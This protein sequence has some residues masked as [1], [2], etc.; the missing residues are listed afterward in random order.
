MPAPRLAILAPLLLASAGLTATG[1]RA[2]I[3][4]DHTG[5]AI[6]DDGKAEIA[7]YEV[8]RAQ[9]QYGRTNPQTFPV[10]TYLVKHNY[11]QATES[12]AN[13]GGI[14]AF[15]WALFYEFESGAYQYKRS[16][17]INSARADLAPL[18]SSFNSFDWCSNLYRE[19]AFEADGD[20]RYLQRSDDYGNAEKSFRA[21]ENAY[22]WTTLPLVV[23][24]LDL[25][26]GAVRF[27][28]LLEDGS[29]V[30]VRAELA[31]HE[32]VETAAGTLEA[33]KIVLRYD[34]RA[35]SLIGEQASSEEHYFRGTDPANLLVAVRAADGRYS[36]VLT[37][38]L[39]SAYWQEDFYPRL[40]RV[41]VRP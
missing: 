23:R 29:T 11:D 3:G 13:R 19:L 33:E 6:W 17:I 5:N 9:D 8:E 24:F 26:S 37:E 35:P 28:L 15:K 10:G 4:P 39:R 1:T 32:D 40:K 36:M 22:P 14:E 16:Y 34:G 25:S 41:N 31:G 38:E 2:Q 12:K 27:D 20:V 30:G 7:F 21:L 18:K